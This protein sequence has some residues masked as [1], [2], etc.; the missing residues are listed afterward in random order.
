MVLFKITIFNHVFAVETINRE[1]Y[2]DLDGARIWSDNIVT[3]GEH[4]EPVKVYLE[5]L[6]KTAECDES[7]MCGNIPFAVTVAGEV[8][9]KYSTGGEIHYILM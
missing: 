9:H 8:R 3:I 6:I 4:T 7:Y 1:V 5:T 2:I